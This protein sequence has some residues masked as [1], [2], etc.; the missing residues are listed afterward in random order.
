[1]MLPSM[2]PRLTLPTFVSDHT[3]AI[4]ALCIEDH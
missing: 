4:E 3:A 2:P 1:M